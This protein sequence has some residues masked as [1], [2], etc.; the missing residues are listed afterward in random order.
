MKREDLHVWDGTVVFTRTVGWRP[1]TDEELADAGLVYFA[2]CEVCGG[3][4]DC[5][6]PEPSYHADCEGYCLN[7]EGF[8][9][10]KV[11]ELARAVM[12]RFGCR[13]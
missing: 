1:V 6:T 13:V 4:G 3:T 8:G 7:C 10:P 5:T 2:D 9:K 12:E 11:A